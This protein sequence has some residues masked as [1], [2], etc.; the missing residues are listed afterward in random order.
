MKLIIKLLIVTAFVVVISWQVISLAAKAPFD[1]DKYVENVERI[2]A[3]LAAASEPEANLLLISADEEDKQKGRDIIENMIEGY[4]KLEHNKELRQKV[5]EEQVK[6]NYRIGKNEEAIR[7]AKEVLVEYPKSEPA[8]IILVECKK[9]KADEF[10]SRGKFEEAVLEYKE[11]LGYSLYEPCENYVTYLM[12]E[13]YIMHGQI[14]NARICYI[15]IIGND[16][17]SYWGKRLK[18]ELR[19]MR[20]R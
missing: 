2:E 7:T 11:L 15:N 14:D 18:D 4:K 12:G 17:H 8:S 10:I 20:N 6:L 5:K 16:S 3:K 1:Y 13:G 19:K 9:M